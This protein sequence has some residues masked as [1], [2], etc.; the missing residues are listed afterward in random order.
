MNFIEW[1]GK[2]LECFSEWQ[3]QKVMD[4]AEALK[5]IPD[6]RAYI[7]GKYNAEVVFFNLYKILLIMILSFIL[8]IQDYF[9]ILLFA[10]ILTQTFSHGLHFDNDL[11][12]LLFSLFEYFAGMYLSIYLGRL[13]GRY[14]PSF[15]L[16][17]SIASGVFVLCFVLFLFYAPAPTRKR[18]IKPKEKK[19]KKKYSLIGLSVSYLISVTM[20]L[21]DKPQYAVL[22]MWAMLLQTICIL[23][24]T[25]KVFKLEQK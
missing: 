16:P 17:A 4:K 10:F 5:L 20:F 19:R 25:F 1:I 24:I 12:C 9:F 6:Q 22:F 7:I 15:L 8:G 13:I 23:P 14:Q 11:F 18:P 2:K 21:I 3:V